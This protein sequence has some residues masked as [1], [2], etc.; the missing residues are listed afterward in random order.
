MTKHVSLEAHRNEQI[1]T[2]TCGGGAGT[3]GTGR[4]SPSLHVS[5]ALTQEV[6]PPL[7]EQPEKRWHMTHSVST[8]NKV[9]YVQCSILFC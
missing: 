9:I 5:P 6:L 3:S 7:I 1:G 2:L 8:L 4:G